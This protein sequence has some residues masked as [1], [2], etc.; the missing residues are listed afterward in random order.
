LQDLDNCNQNLK[1][2]P[3]IYKSS[4]TAHKTHLSIQTLYGNFFFQSVYQD[5]ISYEQMI[6]SIDNKA[7]ELSSKSPHSK[8]STDTTQIVSKYQ[9]LRIQAKVCCQ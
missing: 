8:A 1:H 2:S 4:N 6:E 9:T 7:Q 3:C 5:V